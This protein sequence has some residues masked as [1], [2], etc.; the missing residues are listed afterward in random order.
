MNP[1]PPLLAGGGAWL[2]DSNCDSL[3]SMPATACLIAL[4]CSM[5]A[6]SVSQVFHDHEPDAAFLADIV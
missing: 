1:V 6:A 3:N 2:I 5:R 4:S